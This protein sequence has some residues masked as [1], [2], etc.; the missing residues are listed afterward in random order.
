MTIK[1]LIILPDPILRQVSNPVERVDS[2]IRKLAEDMLETMYDAPG[3]G[4][5]AIQVGVPRRLLVIDVAREGEEKQPLVFINPEIVTS[6]DERSVYEE[7]CLSIPDYYAEVERPATVTVRSIDREGKEQLTE[8]DGL[9]AT[10]LQHE[11]DHLNGVLFI[12]HISRLKREM[13]IKKFTKAAKAK[14]I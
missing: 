4:L 5:A 9:L 14:A 2:D 8:A 10:C 6:S 11:I 13:V 7:G 1:P 3:I 12:D